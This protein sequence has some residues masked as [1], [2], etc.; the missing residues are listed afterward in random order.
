M[1]DLSGVIVG[2]VLVIHKSHSWTF[3]VNDGKH[4]VE[5]VTPKFI[6]CGGMR[7]DNS[8]RSTKRCR[9]TGEPLAY[10]KTV[11]QDN[12]DNLEGEAR[13][14]LGCYPDQLKRLSDTTLRIIIKELKGT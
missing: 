1:S 13:S 9:H 12:R 11:V 5:R 6:F 8:G 10:A 14:R 2:D 7:F 4:A 3:G